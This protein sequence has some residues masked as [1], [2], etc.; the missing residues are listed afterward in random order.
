MTLLKGFLCHL[1][2][3]WPK[4]N[5]SMNMIIYH[6]DLP[7]MNSFL[8]HSHIPGREILVQSDR[9]NLTTLVTMKNVAALVRLFNLG[10]T[11]GDGVEGMAFITGANKCK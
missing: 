2:I 5:F 7:Q 1:P 3:Y 8:T 4:L 9:V 10:Q 6:K 11:G